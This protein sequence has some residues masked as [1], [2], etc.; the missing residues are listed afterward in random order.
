M[1]SRDPKRL[2]RDLNTLKAKYLK[3]S[4]NNR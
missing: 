3:N 2:S 4:S 1:T